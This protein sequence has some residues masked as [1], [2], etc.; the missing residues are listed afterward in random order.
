MNEGTLESAAIEL[1]M[2][3]GYT[4]LK[5]SDISATGEYTEREDYSVVILKE[6]LIN[7]L[8]RINS[9]LHENVIDELVNEIVD[10]K[11]ISLLQNNEAFHK[12]IT[13]GIDFPLEFQNGEIRNTKIFLFDFEEPSNN[14]FV[15]VDQFTVIEHGSE[16]RPDLVIFVNGLPLVV[17]ELKDLANPDVGIADAFNQ[18]KTYQEKIPSLFKFN[19]FNVISDGV[20]SKIGT[21]T[22]NESRYMR[23][24][25]ADG[26]EH[27]S[28]YVPSYETLIHGVFERARFLDIIKNFILFEH[29]GNNVAKILAGYHQFFAVNKALESTKTAYEKKDNRIGVIWHTQGSGKS[30]TMVFY[31]AKLIKS[32]ELKNPTLL[33]ISDR[34]DLDDQLFSTFT[35]AQKILRTEPVQVESRN[36]LKELLNGRESGGVIFTTIQKFDNTETS[37]IL[38]NRSN[39]IVMVDEAHRSQYGFDA[40]YQEE[41]ASLKYGFAKYL[42]DSLP[43]AAYIGF[44]GTPISLVGKDTVGVFGDYIDTYDMTQAVEDGA[45]VKILYESRLAKVELNRE[46]KELID[47]EY[48][49]ITEDQEETIIATKKSKWTRLEAILG[50]KPRLKQLAKDIVKHFE[51]R[52]SNQE[53]YAGKGM[54]VVMSRRIAVDLY[55][56]IIKV[57][58]DWHSDDRAKGKIKVVMTGSSSDPVHWQKH[59]GNKSQREGLG[60]RMKDE[61][62]ELQLVIVRDMWLT[63][64]DVPSV[65]T[66]YIDKQMQGHN[67]M[68]AIA[69]VNRVFKDK[70]GGLIVDYVGIAE[71]LKMALNEYTEKDR[72]NTGIDT[73]EAIAVLLENLELCQ[74]ILHPHDYSNFFTK[75]SRDKIRA[76][77]SSMDFILQKGDKIKRD[78]LDNVLKI[79]KAFSL[80]STTADAQKFNEEIAFHKAV[81]ASLIKIVSLENETKNKSS[82]ELDHEL[83]RLISKSISSEEVIDILQAVGLNK[84]NIA[85]LS[86]EFLEDVKKMKEKNLAIELLKR[87]LKGKIKS[88]SRTNAMQSKKFTE[89]IESTLNKYNSKSIETTQVI[90]ELIDVAKELEEASKR[91]GNIG[92]TQEELAFFD[93]LL[94]VSDNSSEFTAGDAILLSKKIVDVIRNEIPT[95]WQIRESAQAR[96][97]SII[98]RVLIEHGIKVDKHDELLKLIF[99]QVGVLCESFN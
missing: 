11:F 59:T 29:N 22:S 36:H 70:E 16:K 35:K 54:I 67:L 21:L 61:N 4:Y 5:G 80:C 98:K 45:T 3:I 52:Q 10:D 66:M 23:W 12:I 40:K 28:N 15:V 27:P 89:M 24:R 17:I 34:N 87:L 50:A 42:R 32:K 9:E 88:T 30:Y 76:V 78:Y 69:R 81:R 75:S 99:I 86:D 41:S 71:N 96:L 2:S 74:E 47:D 79:V 58:P 7:A 53:S 73:S 62:D 6:R 25:T 18:M 85:I 57:R 44:T 39:V 65:H 55:D 84:P 33:V 26:L 43:N 91:A 46:I 19:C 63:G 49:D 14:E 97:R 51:N 93:I 90:L 20:D 77:T 64:F 60:N 1:F 38:T 68:Q 82:N 8:L 72:K 94:L 95:D 13:D 92:L 31:S 56:E 48:E 37:S 83:N